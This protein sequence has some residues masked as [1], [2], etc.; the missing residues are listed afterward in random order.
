MQSSDRHAHDQRKQ[1]RRRALRKRQR[2][3]WRCVRGSHGQCNGW[4]MG[5]GERVM[6]ECHCHNGYA[7]ESEGL[8]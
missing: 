8:F 7:S 1:A 6:C 2:L 4:R 3:S 5:E